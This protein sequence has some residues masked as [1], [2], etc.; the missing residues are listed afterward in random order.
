MKKWFPILGS[1]AVIAAMVGIGA[2]GVFSDTETTADNQFVAG[3]LDLKID[4]T[5]SPVTMAFSTANMKPG[6]VYNGGWVQLHNA[7][8]IDGVV[9]VQANNLVSNE[10]GL[11]EPEIDAGDLD[12]V[13]IDTDGY[14]GN[15]GDGELW[16][17]ISVKMCYD[18]AYGG[19]QW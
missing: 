17:Q 7:G 14:N 6:S 2:F 1:L 4:G 10:N 8:T 15:T 18:H 3:T 9:T 19:F 13:Q 11:L 12:G 16:D 5:D